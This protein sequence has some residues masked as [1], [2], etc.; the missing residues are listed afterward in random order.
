MTSD[1]ESWRRSVAWGAA[2]IAAVAGGAYLYWNWG[3]SMTDRAKQGDLGSRVVQVEI[4][5]REEEQKEGEPKQ[6]VVS[7]PPARPEPEPVTEG[8]SAAAPSTD[9]SSG[10]GVGVGE[11]PYLWRQTE[12]EVHMAIPVPPELKS[13]ASWTAATVL[14]PSSPD[15][16]YR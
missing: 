9:S 1:S 15:T 14:F 11:V 3:S 5:P 7:G 2:A 6:A 4:L 16:R 12:D 13:K 10:V 8:P